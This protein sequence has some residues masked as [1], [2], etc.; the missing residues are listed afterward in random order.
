MLSIATLTTLITRASAE[1]CFW[2]DKWCFGHRITWTE[3][4]TK[5]LYAITNIIISFLIDLTMVHTLISLSAILLFCLIVYIIIS[6]RGRPGTLKSLAPQQ[7]TGNGNTHSVETHIY[8]GRPDATRSDSHVDDN[9]KGNNPIKPPRD[10]NPNRSD[11][12]DILMWF[13]KLENYLE[14]VLPKEKWFSLAISLVSESCLKNIPPIKN[15]KNSENSYE[16]FK[17][18]MIEKY[19][20]RSDQETITLTTLT[21]R[22]QRGNESSR[23]YGKALREITN[24]LFALTSDTDDVKKALKDQFASGLRDSSLRAKAKEKQYKMK[25]KDFSFDEL[26]EYI[27]GKEIGRE[28]LTGRNTSTTDTDGLQANNRAPF[29]PRAQQN[30]PWHRNEQ[31]PQIPTSVPEPRPPGYYQSQVTPYYHGPPPPY[32][33]QDTYHA[34]QRAYQSN[35]QVPFNVI[36]VFPELPNSNITAVTSNT[37]GNNANSNLNQS[38]QNQVGTNNA[39]NTLNNAGQIEN[40]QNNNQAAPR[41]YNNNPRYN[42]QNNRFNNQNNHNQNNNNQNRQPAPSMNAIN[43]NNLRNRNTEP[44]AKAIFNNSI[45][46][47]LCDTGA[48]QTVISERAYQKIKAQDHIN[49]KLD[50]YRGQGLYSAN[51]VLKIMGTI[52]LKRCIFGKNIE[53]KT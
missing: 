39:N 51:G 36:P 29:Q 43:R 1:W 2:G 48:A 27:A 12:T 40:N 38:N 6:I 33:R 8:V 46:E 9:H 34:P 31:R 50:L 7:N 22:Y 18:A 17:R 28:Q 49:T 5:Y 19:G 14:C 13:V 20:K 47:Y 4:L 41:Y 25:G 24:K 45:I 53:I 44:N 21:E 26:V 3:Y 15:L 52:K 30:N 10:Y 32:R 23:D 42:N 11:D 16:L 35:N 37:S